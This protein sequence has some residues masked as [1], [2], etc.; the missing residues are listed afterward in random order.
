MAPQSSDHAR[1]G[2]TAPAP[3]AVPTAPEPPMRR[4]PHP[5]SGPVPISIR[6]ADPAFHYIRYALSYQN[7][8][9]AEIKTLLEKLTVDQPEP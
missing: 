7:E 3:D 5:V 1:Q 9:L 8:L 6:E 4:W 2:Q